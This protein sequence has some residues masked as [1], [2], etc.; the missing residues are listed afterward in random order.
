MVAGIE[1]RAC[2]PCGNRT[3]REWRSK[4][5]W[6]RW[7]CRVSERHRRECRRRRI[8]PRLGVRAGVAAEDVRLQAS[9]GSDP[10]TGSAVNRS[11]RPDGAL[12]RIR[13][14]W[15][16]L[17]ARHPRDSG[18]R[19]V[20]DRRTGDRASA[21]RADIQR[22]RRLRRHFLSR[23]EVRRVLDG[24]VIRRPYSS[25]I[26]RRSANALRME[27][28]LLRRY[29]RLPTPVFSEAID[30]RRSPIIRTD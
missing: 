13:W 25:A 10:R 1:A 22:R 18:Y 24:S 5:T 4:A 6:L 21:R 12:P 17:N 26:P 11:D 3:L 8:S 7:L 16:G 19:R 30:T 29:R 28:R 15:A 23:A 14:Y 27:R 2:A 20:A 9:R